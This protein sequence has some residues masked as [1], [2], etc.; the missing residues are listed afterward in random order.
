M[1]YQCPY[2]ARVIDIPAQEY[3]TISDNT[4]DCYCTQGS[5]VNIN[6]PF[7]KSFAESKGVLLTP[8]QVE[9]RN[10]AEYEE[11]DPTPDLNLPDGFFEE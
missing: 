8:E 3:F 4:L 1:L 2:D 5:G 9:E 7:Y 11:E 10:E 6:N